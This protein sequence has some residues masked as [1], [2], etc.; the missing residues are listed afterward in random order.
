M[1]W[2]ENRIQKFR[3]SCRIVGDVEQNQIVRNGSGSRALFSQACPGNRWC[4]PPI[5]WPFGVRKER[6]FPEYERAGACKI[7]RRN[8]V[9]L[10]AIMAGFQYRSVSRCC[11]DAVCCIVIDN[12]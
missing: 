10:Y 7:R 3:L 6:S 2:N 9:R 1:S 11:I 4:L 12:V 5:P 8:S